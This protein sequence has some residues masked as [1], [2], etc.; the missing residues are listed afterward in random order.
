[1]KTK[2]IV[3]LS[4]T[5]YPGREEYRLEVD[6]RFTEQ[7]PAF[8]K[9]P[10]LN[11]AWYI[12][13]EVSMSTH[14]GTHIEFP[15]HHRQDGLDAAAFPLESLIGD[16]VVIDISTW[17]Q[18]ERIS[19]E[20]LK[21]VASDHLQ[22]G[23]IAFF[24]T[25]FDRYYHTAQQHDRPWFDTE[26]IRWL[27]EEA[28]I[29]VL[30][31]D[32]SGIEVRALDGSATLGQPNHELLLGAGIPLV[33]YLANLGEFLNQRFSAFILPVKIAGLEA[34]PVRVVGIQWE[35]QDE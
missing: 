29:K 2:R 15:Y 17:G 4:H 9:Y 3:D 19:L 10:R 11:N 26:A 32:T 21:R 33:E 28:R 31:I 1:M 18:N 22:P 24:Y 16:A 6:T 30:G 14:V 7:W 34:F 8:A 5:V 27:V 20:D 23:D 13:S 35:A 12:L 25:G